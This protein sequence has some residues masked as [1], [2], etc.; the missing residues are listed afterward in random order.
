MKKKWMG[1]IIVLL[2]AMVSLATVV[3]AMAQTEGEV[4]GSARP[5]FKVGLAIV[6]PRMALVSDE[7]SMTVFNRQ[8]QVPVNDV[9]IWALTRENADILKGETDRLKEGNAAAV[10]ALDWESLVSGYGIFLGVTKGN[11][12]LKYTFQ[13]ASGH[14]LMA[15]HPE[16][17]PGRTFISIRS[18]PIALE[19]QAPKRAPSEE[20][21]TMTVLQ[22]GT[23]EPVKDAGIWAI[24][25]ENA[26]ALNAE[27][28][29]LKDESASSL[30][31]LDWE[32]LAGI[33][34]FFL[35]STKGNGQLSFTFAEE[36]GYL[37]LAIKPGYFPGRAFIAIRNIP[38]ALMV[39]VPRW[40]EINE[41]FTITV[42]QRTTGEPVK[43]ADIWAL[44]REGAEVFRAEMAKLKEEGT[45]GQ[46]LNAEAIV[47]ALG[48][49]LGVTH[50]NGQLNHTFTESGFY[51]LVAV[52]AG[53]IPGG[54]GIV[55]MPLRT[56]ES[57]NPQQPV[58][59]MH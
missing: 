55:I 49:F 47:S 4:S 34:G 52:K 33:Y 26:E 19:I 24:T 17:F 2:A 41:T 54:A 13:E 42:A 58:P 53:S 20:V 38:D 22:R 35:G 18:I 15:I 57:L 7:V 39:Q 14:V 21:V 27:I 1:I 43:D 25:R 16:Y 44:T 28:T 59:S 9:G 29:R 46:E 37:L 40:A 31:E 11:G 30:Q 48:T 8:N 45:S 6:A 23:V 32:S 10:Q 5:V 50:G 51:L 3:P 12:Q 36:G 56:D